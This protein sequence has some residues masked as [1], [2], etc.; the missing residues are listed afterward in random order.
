MNEEFSY[1]LRIPRDRIGVLIG[2]EGDIKKDIALATKTAIS[3]DSSEGEVVITAK[4]GLRLYEAREVI[5][6]ISRGFNPETALLLLKTDYALD[7]IS[8]V[9]YAGKSKNNMLR[10]KG[11]VIGSEGKA[12]RE[13]ERL[14]N[15]SISVY[16]K[17]VAII[18][19]VADVASARRAVENLLEGATHATVYRFLEKKR[20]A[21]R[22]AKLIGEEI[23]EPK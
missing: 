3:V 8:M 20:R 14:T 13:V 18:G 2:K 10:I 21:R 9:D 16:G 6:A 17:T 7:I 15:C 19:E 1:T 11:R 22:T 23:I 12:K 5:R 4:D